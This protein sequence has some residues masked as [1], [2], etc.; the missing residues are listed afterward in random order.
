MHRY[1]TSVCNLYYGKHSKKLVNQNCKVVIQN[2]K[3][4]SDN[5]R[6]LSYVPCLDLAYQLGLEQRKSLQY[7]IN[8]LASNYKKSI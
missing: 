8:E 5:R 4:P 2:K 1:Y 7:S 3:P 6:R